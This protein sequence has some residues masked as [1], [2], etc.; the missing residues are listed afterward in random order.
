MA[1]L[2]L[3]FRNRLCQRD[4][5]AVNLG[6]HSPPAQ[7]MVIRLHGEGVGLAVVQLEIARERVDSADAAGLGPD[8]PFERCCDEPALER[9]GI[10]GL[11]Q[12]GDKC[13]EVRVAAHEEQQLRKREWRDEIHTREA[14]AIAQAELGRVRSD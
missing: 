3:L 4:Y 1:L 6:Q 10:A 2:L 7:H 14:G 9:S 12:A 13:L 11:R 5:Y 8:L